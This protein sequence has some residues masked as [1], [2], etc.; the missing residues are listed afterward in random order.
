M[1]DLRFTSWLALETGCSA[2]RAWVQP[3]ES[4]GLSEKPENGLL[5]EQLQRMEDPK[6]DTQRRTKEQPKKTHL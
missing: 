3:Q 2:K 6:L 1:L 5:N 4:L